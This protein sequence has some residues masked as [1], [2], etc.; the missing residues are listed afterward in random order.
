MDV[1]NLRHPSAFLKVIEIFLLIIILALYFSQLGDPGRNFVTS[2]VVGCFL[3]ASVLLTL[4]FMGY[5]QIQNTPLEL[6]FYVYYVVS[7][8]ISAILLFCTGNGPFVAAG[9]FC[10]FIMVVYCA[11]WYYAFIALNGHPP[12]FFSG[13]R[14]A[15]ETPS[16]QSHQ[17]GYQQRVT[18]SVDA[19]LPPSEDIFHTNPTYPPTMNY[20]P[21][22]IGMK[23]P[24]MFPVNVHNPT[25][26]KP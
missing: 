1:N 5:N 4:R 6:I 8:F 14:P 20:P 12:Q 26:P 3:N 17:S 2:V 13:Q 24:P 21:I 15:Q 23:L 22:N 25:D 16:S 11:D 10:L 18:D 9:F 7:L 19:G